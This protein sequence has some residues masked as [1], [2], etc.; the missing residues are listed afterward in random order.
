MLSKESKMWAWG[1]GI[2]GILLVVCS[3]MSTQ[4]ITPQKNKDGQNV[5]KPSQ[6]AWGCMGIGCLM[7]LIGFVT[8]MKM[9]KKTMLPAMSPVASQPM[10]D[11]PLPD[12]S[13]G[14]AGGL[15]GGAGGL[16]GGAGGL[17]GM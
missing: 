5:C 17:G 14:G 10:T 16:G 4:H 13:G 3:F 9:G 1:V 15:G 6:Y 7:V 8:L 11:V 12:M 2:G